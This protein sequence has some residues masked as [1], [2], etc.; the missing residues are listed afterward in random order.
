MSDFI[1]RAHG[2]L[3]H[4]PV[5]PWVRKLP[6]FEGQLQFWWLEAAMHHAIQRARGH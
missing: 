1:L 3:P 5:L 4:H 2:D 6:A